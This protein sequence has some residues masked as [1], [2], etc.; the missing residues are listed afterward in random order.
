MAQCI[1]IGPVCLFV[2]GCV[3]GSVTTKTRNSV[4]RSSPN[5][6]VGKGSDHFQLIK[7]WPS[8]AHGK[9][10]ATGREFLALPYYSQRAV[11]ASPLSAFFHWIWYAW[12]L[13]D[14]QYWINRAAS[15]SED[16]VSWLESQCPSM[17]DYSFTTVY[18]YSLDVGSI[19]CSPH[20]PFLIT[21]L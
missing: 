18:W 7:F 8:R 4:H 2:C 3:G 20:V 6:F 21:G 15:I 5:W 1:V 9:G 13:W 17:T 16:K 14:T 19:Y 12:W 11:F 10:S